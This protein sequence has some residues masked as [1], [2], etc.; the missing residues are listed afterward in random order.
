MNTLQ[1][2]W[3]QDGYWIMMV[4]DGWIKDSWI[5]D[6]WMDGFQQLAD[7]WVDTRCMDNGWMATGRIWDVLL[8]ALQM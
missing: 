4:P 3:I 1:D 5:H 7:E 6:N 2:S 8:L